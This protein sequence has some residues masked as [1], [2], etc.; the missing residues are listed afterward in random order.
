MAMYGATIGK[1][2][3]LAKAA[4]C[5]Q[6]CCALIAKRPN[7]GPEY[8]FLAL[9][10]R[11]S[12]IL[13]LR[14]GAAQQNI[15]QEVIKAFPLLCPTDD[16]MERFNRLVAPAMKLIGL[17]QAK[18]SILRTTRDMLLPKLISGEIP[19][20]AADDTAAELISPRSEEIALHA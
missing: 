3:I 13:A 12:D 6:A 11:R 20:R 4:T 5:N 19:V 8:I 15:S 18:N 10:I 14:M 16:V 7:F 17:L 2:G 9:S 1:L